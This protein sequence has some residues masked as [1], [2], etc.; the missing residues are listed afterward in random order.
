MLMGAIGCVT[1]SKRQ[2]ERCEGMGF[3]ANCGDG[4]C[5]ADENEQTCPADCADAKVVSYNKQTICHGVE[6]VV[7]PTSTAEVQAAV[8]RARAQSKPIRVIGRR[9][10]SNG[11]LCNEGI[12]VS[13]ARLDRAL[14][15]APRA[16]KE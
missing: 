7:E 11:Q 8:R 6:E 14:H 16:N 1:F 3:A 5:S 13:T 9:H 2:A 12:I 10:T 4:T 15:I